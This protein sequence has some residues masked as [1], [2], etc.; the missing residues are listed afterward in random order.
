[1]VSSPGRF[2]GKLVLSCEL[3]ASGEVW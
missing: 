2:G 3:S 1:V